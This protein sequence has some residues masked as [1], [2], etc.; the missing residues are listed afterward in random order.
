MLYFG[1]KK[2]VKDF[3]KGNVSV[4]G[5]VGTGKDML[6]ANVIQ[7][8]RSDYISNLDY[9][10]KKLC[11]IPFKAED[12]NINNDFR[13]FLTGKLN[14]YVYPYKDNID[15]YISDAG[16]YFP[17]QYY[18]KLDKE[19]DYLPYFFALTRHLGNC[20]VHYN[21]QNLNRVY[22]KVREMSDIYYRCLSC[23]VFFGKV[24]VL[25]VM[26]YDKLQ[27]CLDRV[28]TF[29]PLPVPLLATQT[30]KQTV[31]THND[32]LRSEYRNK[33]GLVERNTFI[34]INK[35]KYDTRSFKKMLSNG[36]MINDTSFK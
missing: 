22:D 10:I 11:F 30:A 20:N 19:F 4:S 18:S 36:G 2:V 14:K 16:L 5:L 8:R 17:S 33:Y 13:S 26:K 35:S 34:F 15:I 9:N 12:Y 32:S 7:R 23:K 21:A 25:T 31:R 29:K 6:F 24:V 28:S 3:D 27:S 1:L